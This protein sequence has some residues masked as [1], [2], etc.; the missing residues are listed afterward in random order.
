MTLCQA[1]MLSFDV[2]QQWRLER[3]HFVKQLE[4]YNCGPI[5]CTKILEIFGLVTK[6]EVDHAY[7]IGTIRNLVTEQWQRFLIRCNDDLIVRIQQRRPIAVLREEYA[8]KGG[9][10]TSQG[11]TSTFDP[12]DIC[13]CFNDE[14]HM[15]ILHLVCCKQF[16]HRDCLLTWLEF[17]S[18]CPYCRRPIDDIASIQSHPV[19]DRTKDL[20]RTPTMTPKQRRIGRKRDVQEMELDDAFGSPTPQRLADKMRSISQEKK[21]DSQI[22]QAARMVATRS[23]DVEKKGV[24]I[25]AVVTVIPDHRAVSHSV[26]IVGIVYKMKESGGAQVATVVGLL[27][28]SGKKDWWIPDDQYILRYPPHVDAPIP[29]DLQEIRESILEGTYNTAAKAKRCTIQEVHKVITNQVSPQKM[30]KCSCLKGKC[31]P[32]RCGCATR[33]RKCT[34]ACTCNGNCTN[35]QNGK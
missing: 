2:S 20:S 31:N 6:F 8:S 17:E 11:D 33:Q 12:L 9:N 1:Y 4:G 14:S 15:D 18:S 22:K 35:P 32:K 13:F 34:S 21:R 25:G 26:G 7:G 29:V 24:G 10:M 30:G 19:I 28:Q 5:A 23:K 27:V 16:I 3:G